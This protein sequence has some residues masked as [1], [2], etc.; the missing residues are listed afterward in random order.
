VSRPIYGNRHT[1]N[2]ASDKGVDKLIIKTDSKFLIDS[3]TKYV[4]RWRENGWVKADGT[5][6]KNRDDFQEYE[7]VQSRSNT[8]VTFDKVPAHTGIKGNNE[9]DRL[10]KEARTLMDDTGT[11][12]VHMKRIPRTNSGTLVRTLVDNTVQE[13]LKTILMT[14]TLVSTLLDGISDDQASGDSRIGR[15]KQ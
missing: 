8:Q 6:V 13:Q 12:Q 3:M 11:V 2:V 10:A 5:P 4:P 9:A 1:N 7:E 15:Q 14:S